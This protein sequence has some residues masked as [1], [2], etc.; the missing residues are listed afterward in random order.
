VTPRKA[1]QSADTASAILRRQGMLELLGPSPCLEY[2]ISA[3][4]FRAPPRSVLARVGV[5]GVS[6]P[7][8]RGVST[9]AGS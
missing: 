6:D 1:Y 7:G 5:L 2:F 3:P 9:D 4:Q 8:V